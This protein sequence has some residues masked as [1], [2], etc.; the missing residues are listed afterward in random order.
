M[1]LIELT[2]EIKLQTRSQ[3][4][5]LFETL[6]KAVIFNQIKLKKWQQYLVQILFEQR[7]I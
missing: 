6:I 5:Q 7:C 1:F 2:T 3:V 4:M